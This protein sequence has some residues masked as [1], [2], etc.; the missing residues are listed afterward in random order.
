MTQLR[1]ERVL[2]LP[3]TKTGSTFYIVKSADTDLAEVY[4]TSTD[5]TEIR[6]LINK[7]EI[8]TIVNTAVGNFNNMLLAADVAARDALLLTK[9]V[10]VLVTDATGDAT[11]QAG[12]ALYFYDFASTTYIKV[13]EYESLD[14]T[15]EWASI[16]NKPSSSVADIDDAVA[17]KHAHV[18]ADQLAKIGEDGDGNLTYNGAQP[19]VPLAVAAW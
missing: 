12:A 14:V 1:I 4:F 17:K 10:L 19:G 2:A 16:Q 6:H 18:N 8:Q 3:E 9:N 13:A 11:V 7:S 5:G 15:L